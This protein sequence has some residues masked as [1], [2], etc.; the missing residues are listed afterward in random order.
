MYHLHLPPGNQSPDRIIE[1][2]SMPPLDGTN[3]ESPGKQ[4]GSQVAL[5]RHSTPGDNRVHGETNDVAEPD[6]KYHHSR[7]SSLA[8]MW[9]D[10]EKKPYIMFCLIIS[11]TFLATVHHL[12]YNHLDGKQA[13]RQA[14]VLRCGTALGFLTKAHLST[15]AVLAFRQRTWMTIRK[16]SLSLG[17]VDSLFAAPGDFSALFSWEILKS[18][19]ISLCL[20]IYIW[21]A[22]LLVIL[23]S[24]TL[25]VVPR[26][27]EE[28]SECS[29]V[30]TLN[31]GN[32]ETYDFRLP[33]K[34]EGRSLLSISIW[35]TTAT[36]RNVDPTDP[37][38]FDYWAL[39]S[40]HYEQLAARAVYQRTT[41]TRENASKQVCKDSFNCSFVIDFT[42]PGYKCDELAV[43][44]GSKVKK[45]GGLKAPFTTEDIVPDG[46]FSYLA[47][48]GQGDYARQQV[49]CTTSGFPRKGPPYPKNLG[50]WRTE[51]IIWIGY[52]AVN[53][54]EKQ[55]P[56]NR[57]VDGWYDA[58]TPV[59]FGCEHYETN[60]RIEF[61]YVNGKEFHVVKRREFFRKI[62]NTTF[63]PNETDN[64]G[65]FDNT[66]A[67]PKSNYIFPRDTRRY[68]RTAAYHAMGASL[69]SFLN[70]TIV[71]PY[72]R[73]NTDLQV[74][75]LLDDFSYLAIKDLRN[76][77]QP[78][79]E[80][81]ILSLLSKPQFLAV[82][83][84]KS[85]SQP[86]GTRVG[87][88]ETNYPC[89]RTRP[90]VFY[91]YRLLQLCLVYG[92][93]ILLATVGAC[94]GLQ[95][96]REEGVMRDMKTSSI[97]AVTRAQQLD[98]VRSNGDR[99]SQ[100]LKIAFGWVRE[101][102]GWIR[103]FGLEGNVTQQRLRPERST[104]S[105]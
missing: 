44:R 33:K 35:N 64:D 86:S 65:T 78:F 75:R 91:E 36:G 4:H 16:R 24:D 98:V 5:L 6:T 14:V 77:I 51:P 52:G 105:H 31:F 74:T 17:A 2:N 9:R 18:A 28:R 26:I 99:D 63:I 21:A 54:T 79:Y 12:F 53:D 27:L 29:S 8:E 20:A 82:A 41:V 100:S 73:M 66:T 15:A 97:I 72:N 46:N 84:A 50:A 89:I 95:A 43:G 104:S 13:E 61:N 60:Y 37:D 10:F 92:L 42:G 25:S 58:Y 71:P 80:E 32:E 103:G 55:Q 88:A 56:K 19:R 48:T 87:G 81:M 96:A 68:R 11:G 34:I 101:S 102:N 83:W 59:V 94:S 85:P 90:S 67:Y 49:D 30:R 7:L 57:T 70:G 23:T 22:P 3:D 40:P 62:I 1:M 39:T 76:E 47:I 45:L 38:S 69:R 93:S